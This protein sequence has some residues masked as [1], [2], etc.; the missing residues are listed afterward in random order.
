MLMHPIIYYTNW[1][2][3]D[4]CLWEHIEQ[5]CVWCMQLSQSWSYAPPFINRILKY[6]MPKCC[7]S[8]DD[9]YKHNEEIQWDRKK[10]NHYW[11]PLKMCTWKGLQLHKISL[12]F[13]NRLTGILSGYFSRIRADSACLLSEHIIASKIITSIHMISNYKH[14]HRLPYVKKPS[15]QEMLET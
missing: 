13:H 15:W 11:L 10:S 6:F 1:Q 5:V 12:K 4:K 9:S 7:T 3:I 8:T 2:S 14:K